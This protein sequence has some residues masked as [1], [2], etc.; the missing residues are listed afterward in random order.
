MCEEMNRCWVMRL[1]PGEQCRLNDTSYYYE[2]ARKEATGLAMVPVRHNEDHPMRMTRQRQ[3]VLD[4]VGK[5]GWHPTGDEVYRLARRRLP[6]ISLGTVYRN[7]DTLSSQGSI[8]RIDIAG[9][10]KRF[11]GVVQAHYHARC[12]S[13]G[14]I[15]DVMAR[16]AFARH[17]A[18]A[19]LEGW[20]ITG[21][22]LE[23]LG[24]CPEC[25]ASAAEP[26]R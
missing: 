15:E 13:C 17:K 25:R 22:R 24:L 6:R 18:A 3:A 20:E 23:L 26:A 7:L 19:A 10:P 14:R 5:P 11:D 1:V 9:Q 2:H 4:I 8:Q 16:P 21:R 12:V